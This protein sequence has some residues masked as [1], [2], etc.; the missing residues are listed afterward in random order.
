MKKRLGLGILA[1]CTGLTTAGVGFAAENIEVETQASVGFAGTETPVAIGHVD[2]E[3]PRETDPHAPANLGATPM[4]L[5]LDYASRWQFDTQKMSLVDR[6]YTAKQDV[7][8]G[9]AVANHV[10]VTDQRGQL[11]GWDLQVRQKTPFVHEKGAELKGA[12]L[13]I[14][15]VTSKSAVT[16]TTV[17]TAKEKMALNQA[18]MRLAYAK[19][20][21]GYGTTAIS[22]GEVSLHVPGQM[23]KLSGN[24]N[25][26]IVYKLLAAPTGE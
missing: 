25:S 1:I 7:F 13:Q 2:P 24:Y 17:L 16:D 15:R 14:D 26:T 19:P 18:F 3:A 5:T 11:D 23:K 10:Q 6:T 12:K 4:P 8:A 22:L 20:G 9:R 21:D